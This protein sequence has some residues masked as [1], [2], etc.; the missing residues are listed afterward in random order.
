VQVGNVQVPT[1]ACAVAMPVYTFATV[2]T[3]RAK[4]FVNGGSQAV[5]LPRDCRF[6]E[7]EI[8]VLARRV[9]KAVI[10]EAVDEW[11]EDFLACLGSL[12]QHIER[13]K[14]PPIAALRDPFA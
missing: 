3:T 11:P 12:S 8:E 6:P 5:R 7:G 9:G 10:L 4:L 1:R 13:P 14:S 2:K